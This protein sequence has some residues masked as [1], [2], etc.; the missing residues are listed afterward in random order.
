M[1]DYLNNFQSFRLSKAMEWKNL[2]IKFE[3][4]YL[5]RGIQYRGEQKQAYSCE[6]V[7]H[8]VYLC[9]VIYFYIIYL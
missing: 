2:L 6:Y 5:I 1:Q 3:V 9:I 8:R 4:Q 7:K